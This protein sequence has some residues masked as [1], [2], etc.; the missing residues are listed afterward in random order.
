MSVESGTGSLYLTDLYSIHNI[1]QNTLISYPLDLIIGVL[2]NFFADDSYF[3]YVADQYGFPLTPNM[4]D[5]E[6]DAGLNNDLATRIF[7]GRNFRNDV[8]FY[9]AILVSSGSANYTPI[10][11]NRNKETVKWGA[12]RVFDGYGNETYIHTPEAFVF[13]GAWTGTIN[14]DIKARSIQAREELVE[15]SMMCFTDIRFEELLRAG[16]LIQGVSAGSPSVEEDNNH[17]LF[18]QTITLNYRGE[19]R[20]EIPIINIIDAINICVDFGRLTPQPAT[21]APNLT[22]N[23]A[24]ELIDEIQ[25]L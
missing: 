24:V 15:T 19:W 20:R 7:I 13:A 1:V 21:L 3:H 12:T 9:P 11:M 22:V 17:K 4:T 18:K 16:V 14:V 5:V 23:T 2:R 6:V 25:N 10:S 8:I